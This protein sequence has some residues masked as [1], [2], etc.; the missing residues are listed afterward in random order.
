ML[1][2][3]TPTHSHALS[4]NTVVAP[5]V[6]CVV[7]T[8]SVLSHRLSLGRSALF[9]HGLRVAPAPPQTTHSFPSAP[10][11]PQYKVPRSFKL[12]EEL[13][14]AEKGKYPESLADVVP[15]ISLGLAD[16][17]D[18]N[19]T[20]WQ[21]SIIP[22]QVRTPHARPRVRLQ[23][24]VH[25]HLRLS[26]RRRTLK[27]LPV[28]H[29][30]LFRERAF[31]LVF[32][33]GCT[34]SRTNT[35]HTRAH[36]HPRT[37]TLARTRAHTPRLRAGDTHWGAHVL[38]AD[39]GWDWLPRVAAADQVPAESRDPGCGQWCVRACVFVRACVRRSV[40]L[41]CVAPHIRE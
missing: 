27:A 24:Y 30:L 14:G 39:R 16:G 31:P 23:T 9:A 40:S 15:F 38:S 25:L 36:E 2:L 26:L 32:L 35:P 41:A 4:C 1:R 12:L 29:G 19:L 17:S 3:S 5:Q 20:T 13:E 37:R 28:A 11:P 8:A 6:S 10:P 22:D 21:A 33:C 18:M 7:G 34:R